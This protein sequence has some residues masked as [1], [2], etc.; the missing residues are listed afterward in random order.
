MNESIN[1]VGEGG[2]TI[3]DRDNLR[4][5]V[6]R[7]LHS[8]AL[9][10]LKNTVYGTK[11]IRYQ[12]TNQETKVGDLANPFFFHLWQGDELIGMYCLDERQLDIENRQVTGFYG[13]YLSVAES[14]SNKGYGRLLKQ[15]AMDY[16]EQHTSSPFLFYSYIE[17]KNERS[18]A[19]SL[20]ENFRSVARLKTYFFRRYAPVEDK[21]FGIATA[22]ELTRIIP[23]LSR[24]Y[25]HYTFKTFAHV[26]YQG[27]YFVLREGGQ[28]VAGIQANPVCWRFIQM[29]GLWG[30]LIMKLA[31]LFPLT[32]WYFNPARQAFAVLEGFYH[33]EGRAHLLPVLLESVLAHLGLHSAMWQIDERDPLT[34]LL[35]QKEMGSFSSFRAGINTHVLVKSVGTPDS[36]LV[37]QRPLY[38]SC[39]DYS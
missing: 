12:H 5:T 31:P 14:R 25:R 20:N 28:I 10:L 19:I 3:Y 21:R 26:G 37:N 6:G 1:F 15:K 27:Q 29:P 24:F 16:T 34:A 36:W 4:I 38:I 8:E 17:E 18:M 35:R 13:R 9:M 7:A 22:A 11:G 23:L 30:P 32:R 33:S 2:E 39:F